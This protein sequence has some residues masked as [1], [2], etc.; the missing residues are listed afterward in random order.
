MTNDTTPNVHMN[1][2]L[3]PSDRRLLRE[4]SY[5]NRVSMCE[6]VRL[7][8]RQMCGGRE[9]RPIGGRVKRSRPRFVRTQARRVQLRKDPDWRQ[10]STERKVLNQNTRNGR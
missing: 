9:I 5:Q 8:I 3:T 6:A 2:I 7:G 1:V 4:W 10:G